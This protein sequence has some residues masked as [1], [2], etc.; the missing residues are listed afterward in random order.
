MLKL[1]K[2]EMIVAE[3]TRV[4]PEVVTLKQEAIDLNSMI[5]FMQLSHVKR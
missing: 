4:V 5:G 2:E 3:T 1:S